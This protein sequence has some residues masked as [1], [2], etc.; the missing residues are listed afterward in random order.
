ML[1]LLSLFTSQAQHVA[2]GCFLL[3]CQESIFSSQHLPENCFLYRL[4]LTD[5]PSMVYTNWVRGSKVNPTMVMEQ[6]TFICPIVSRA[7]N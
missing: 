7:D 5:W 2:K 3:I 4:D 6:T 1:Q